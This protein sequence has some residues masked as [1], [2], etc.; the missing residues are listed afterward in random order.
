MWMYSQEPERGESTPDVGLSDMNRG[1]GQ[2]FEFQHRLCETLVGLMAGRQG[3]LARARGAF[4]ELYR[5]HAEAVYRGLAWTPLARHYGREDLVQAAFVRAFERA[6]TF[7][8]RG[9]ADEASTTHVRAWLR[10]IARR[11]VLEQAPRDRNGIV[12]V[13]HVTRECWAGMRA[14]IDEAKQPV[15][16]RVQQLREE[17]AALP[18]RER[19]ILLMYLEYHDSELARQHIPDEVQDELCAQFDI[20][21]ANLRK[22]ISRQ[23]R[24]LADRLGKQ[25][26]GKDDGAA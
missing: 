7:T 6:E 17:L 8:P 13:I 1:D 20:G 16:R 15:P 12:S 4:E 22:I 23:L 2:P 19:T 5:R 25:A 24:R 14:A 9:L 3:A 18:E 26:G 21:R 11:I 10:A